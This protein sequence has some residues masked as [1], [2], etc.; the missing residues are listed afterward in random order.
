[1]KQKINI[2]IKRNFVPNI[3][4]RKSIEIGLAS[5]QPTFNVQ[6]NHALLQITCF[7]MGRRLT[8]AWHSHGIGEKKKKKI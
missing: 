3:S 7:F 2:D 4:N 5:H 8:V 6:E 1:M